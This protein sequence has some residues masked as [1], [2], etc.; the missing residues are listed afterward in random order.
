MKIKYAQ[1]LKDIFLSSVTALISSKSDS[2]PY[3]LNKLEPQNSGTDFST[4]KNI[5]LSPKLII[6]FNDDNSYLA[7]SHASHSSHSSHASHVSHSSHYSG[8]S[9]HSS[10]YS[11]LPSHSS[12]Y[13][14]Y[15]SDGNVK[16]S[17]SGTNSY[18]N[19][20][21]SYTKHSSTNV[22]NQ[23]TIYNWRLGERILKKGMK[24]TDV[25]DLLNILTLKGYLERKDNNI[26]ENDEFTFDV[27]KAVRK[28]QKANYL[29]ID[30]IVG[31]TTLLFLNK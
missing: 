19:T 30:G 18:Y 24:G 9:S 20:P 13:S 3:D 26:L 22:Y 10:H 23:Q 12:H 16:P 7:M 29:A 2:L 5:D 8:S 6:K 27:E 4:N 1:F 25:K 17:S 31:S 14:S 11:S 21:N 15:S 28:F